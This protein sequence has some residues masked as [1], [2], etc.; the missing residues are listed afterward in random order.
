MQLEPDRGDVVDGLFA[1]RLNVVLR[2]ILDEDVLNLSL[3][4]AVA[5]WGALRTPQHTYSQT[6]TTREGGR[7]GQGAGPHSEGQHAEVHRPQ[8][9]AQNPSQDRQAGNMWTEAYA[10]WSARLTHREALDRMD[11]LTASSR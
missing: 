11:T 3:G 8:Y 9:L 10:G 1:P 5:L 2:A 6:F 4:G 7:M